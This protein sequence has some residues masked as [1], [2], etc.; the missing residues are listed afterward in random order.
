MNNPF[1]SSL[2]LD[3]VSQHSSVGSVLLTVYGVQLAWR[4]GGDARRAAALGVAVLVA[5]GV[6][7]SH[8]RNRDWRT[9]ETL[10]R[11]FQKLYY[12]ISSG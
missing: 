4:R 10:L 11:Y 5:A 3:L 1:W 12:G 8:L 2:A 6:A 9:R 7:R